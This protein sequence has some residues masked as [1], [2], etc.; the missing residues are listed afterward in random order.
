MRVASYWC[1]V[2]LKPVHARVVKGAPFSTPSIFS[3]TNRPS[4]S[5]RI[6]EVPLVERAGPPGRDQNVIS[7]SQVPDIAASR[8]CSGAGLAATAA[9]SALIATNVAINLTRRRFIDAP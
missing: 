5:G 4:N 8:T 1:V 3:S 9:A 2:V 6:V 7:T